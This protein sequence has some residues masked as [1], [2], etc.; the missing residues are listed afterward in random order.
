MSTEKEYDVV[1]IG[2]GIGGLSAARMLAEFGNRKVL[3]LEQHFTLGGMMHEFTRRGRFHFGTGVHYLTASP[4]NGLNYLT[5]GN[6][7]FE[8]L[9][10]EYDILHFPDFDFSIPASGDEFRRR[11]KARFPDEAGAVDGF[12]AGVRRASRGTIARHV[13]NS[14]APRIRALALPVIEFLFPDA[15][16]TIKTVVAR[17]FNDPAI[18]AIVSAR[19]GLYGGPPSVSAFGSHSVVSLQGFQDGGSHPIGGPRELTRA[20][21]DGLRRFGV[22][23]RERQRVQ[24]I[25][26]EDGQAVGVIVL[27]QMTKLPYRIRSKYVVSAI[28]ARN[29]ASLLGEADAVSWERELSRLPAEIGTL[30]LFI[31]FK[32]S[33]AS[34]GLS[35]ENHWF[36]PSYDDDT[37]LDHPIGEGVLFASF[38]SLNNPAAYYHTAEIMQFVDPASFE[39]WFGTEQGSRSEQYERL[40]VVATERLIERMNERWP[41]FRE[42]IAFAELGTPL[43]FETFQ[44]SVHGAI[45]GLANSPERLRSPIA[46]CRTDIGGLY[47]SGQDATSPGI[48]AALWGGITTANAALNGAQSRRMWR[49]IGKRPTSDRLGP[50]R[51]YMLVSRI[52]SLTPSIKRIRLETFDGSD[53]PFRLQAGQYVKLE[54]PVEGGTI[55]RSYS[56]ASPPGQRRFL[57][58]AVKLEA[59]GLG[60]TFLHSDLA[61][62]KAIRLSAP[63]GEFAADLMLGD[64]GHGALLL[65]AG[66][67]GITPIM[68]VLEAAAAARHTGSITLLASFRT[69]ADIL[70]RQEIERLQR[71]IPELTVAIFLTAP[72]HVWAG[73][74]GRIDRQALAP[75]INDRTHAYLCGPSSMMQELIG[76]LDALGLSREAIHTEAFVSSRTKANLV[77]DARAIARAAEDSR[78]AS[79]SV[80]IAHSRTFSCVPGQTILAAANEERIPFAQSCHE[81]ACGKCRARILKGQFTTRAAGLLSSREIADGWVL[82]CQTLPQG[83]LEISLSADDVAVAPISDRLP[84]QT[85][86]SSR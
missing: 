37:A 16:R 12:F 60:S 49:A 41:G 71:T 22:E 7:G 31:G 33:P 56:I 57:E 8:R 62:G 34:L 35:G 15:F 78:V 6:V 69:E 55:E 63:F 19:W 28:G 86:S 26:V 66:G 83:D 48:E 65:V 17:H 13:V 2:S 76:A 38:S 3:V 30:L 47:L 73:C 75:F 61:E 45:Y 85:Q 29:T 42:N 68:S 44:G 54:L 18:R 72:Q 25:M 27:D 32:H 43:S 46:S 51:G 50:W 14:L 20:I 59:H 84:P 9:P 5:D 79:F 1:V 23:L 74:H 24:S 53:L 82:T 70:F 11:L 67:I 52:D 80:H 39:T 77:E 58:L 36:M 64:G 81:G 4:S 21:I 40:K 10:Y